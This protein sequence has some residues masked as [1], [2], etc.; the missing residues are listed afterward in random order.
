MA[1][2]NQCPICGARINFLI[3]RRDK[4]QY[5]YCRN[6]TL[7][8]SNPIPS[9]E[10]L[11]KFYKNYSFR[12][13]KN[14]KE[15]EIKR[16]EISS[17]TEKIVQDIKE[18][19]KSPAPT[20]LD[21]GGGTGFYSNAF[22]L[23][24]FQVTLVDVNKSACDYA[25]KKFNTFKVL[26]KDLEK[27]QTE[28]KF[29]VIFINQVIEHQNN[30]KKFLS[31]VKKLLQKDGLVILT[32][33]NQ[34]CKEFYFRPLWLYYYLKLTNKNLI[35]LKSFLVFLKKPWIACD[36]PRHI[37]AFNEKS[38]KF[39]LRENQ[40]EVLK[41]FTEYSTENHYSGKQQNIKQINNMKDILKIPFNIFTY[42]GLFLL[43]LVDKERRYGSNL[44][45]FA[46]LRDGKAQKI[47]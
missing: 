19:I 23:N 31:T 22:A 30:L 41:I 46:T 8:L 18:Y 42:L 33:P 15:F 25:V 28:N 13:P 2:Q 5:Y 12:K 36:P 9:N 4:Y 20:L 45:V 27:I 26:H 34:G 37:F 38:L 11:S 35:P 1:L 17:D 3:K 43:K 24:G 44:V 14:K 6:C 39:L 10:E 7:I 16:K 32:T 21:Y 29:D 40:F 47:L